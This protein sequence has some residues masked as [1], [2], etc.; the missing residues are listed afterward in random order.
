MIIFCI[1][2]SGLC[3]KKISS[4]GLGLFGDSSEIMERGHYEEDKRVQALHG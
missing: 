2:R 3:I 1:T 4:L